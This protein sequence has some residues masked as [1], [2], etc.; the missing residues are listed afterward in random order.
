MSRRRFNILWI[1][2]GSVVVVIAVAWW[3]VMSPEQA[4]KR[5]EQRQ[6][7]AD[8]RQFVAAFDS[9]CE[10]RLLPVVWRSGAFTKTKFDD[11]L[12]TWTLTIS[13]QDWSRRSEASKTDLV[14]KLFVNFAGTRA[15]AGREGDDLT[16]IVEDD[17]DQK[18]A[19]CT[20]P[21]GITI[22]K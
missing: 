8:Q 3:F 2:L 7:R 5:A 13:P 18:L 22:Y 4:S 21:G 16:L 14:T 1:L 10:A 19:E 9:L 12:K 11:D 20:G 17:R 15:Q 6:A